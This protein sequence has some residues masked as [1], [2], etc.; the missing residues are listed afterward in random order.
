M[1]EITGTILLG[2]NLVLDTS[3]IFTEAFAGMGL[4]AVYSVFLT[5]RYSII[6]LDLLRNYIFKV[7]DPS[8]DKKNEKS[9]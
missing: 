9:K 5:L 6:I 1:I 2:I 4:F 3:Y 7:C 8:E